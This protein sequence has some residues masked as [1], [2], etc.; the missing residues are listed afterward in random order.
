MKLRRASFKNFRVLRDLE[1]DFTTSDERKL[2]VIRAENGGGK[3]TMLIALQWALYGDRALPDPASDFQFY[4]M[5][6]DASD[7]SVVETTVSVDFDTVEVR[8][9]GSGELIETPRFYRIVR[10]ASETLSGTDWTRG[11]STARLFELTDTGA[12]RRDPPEA[13]IAD[14]LP[15]ELRE[16]FFTDGDRALTFI[17]SDGPRSAQR[18]RVRDAVQSLLGLDLIQATLGHVDSSLKETN[19]NARNVRAGGPLEEVATNIG[20]VERRIGERESE[21]SDARDQRDEFD[22]RVA[23]THIK[24]E[25]ALIRGDQE[26]LKEDIERSKRQI[27]TLDEQERSIQGEHSRLFRSP[28]FSCDLAGRTLYKGLARL[29]ELRDQGKFPK[30]AIPVLQDRLDEGVCICGELLDQHEAHGRLRRQHIESLIEDSRSADAVQGV[31]T[32]LYHGVAL[33]PI[34]PN[35]DAT[36]WI[37]LYRDVFERRDQLQLLRRHEGETLKSLEAQV[38]AIGDVDLQELRETLRSFQEQSTRALERQTKSQTELEGLRERLVE[39]SRERDSLLRAE[40]LGTRILASLDV[41]Q[42]I[43][44]ALSNAHDRIA[45]EE[46]AKVSSCMNDLFLEMIGTDPEQVSTIRRAEISPEFD[47]RVYGPY[48]RLLN[49]DNGLSGAQRRALTVSFVLALTQ[50]SEAVAPN[51]I[52]TPLGTMSGYVKRS[53]LRSAI[54]QSSQIVLF[55]TR[56]EIAGCEDI[57]DAEAGKVITLTNTEHYPQKLVNDPKV[58]TISALRCDCNHRKWCSIC[59]IRLDPGNVESER[60]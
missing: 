45:K 16:V 30:T 3:T 13:V 47:I 2:T 26:Q 23:E 39:L 5:D 6:W 58:D 40:Q 41:T 12:N 38:E 9:S 55:L 53:V 17:E 51:V 46:L 56:A 10:S 54:H 33:L 19:R 37:D 15:I 27:K 11:A 25:A 49:P 35:Q 31:L 7:G 42:D 28:E 60:L 52:D 29:S 32:E 20:D 57:L 24:V 21:I 34:E 18:K 14:E 8:G 22:S 48:D 36:G 1:I 59:E 4:P 50:V 43:K 44:S